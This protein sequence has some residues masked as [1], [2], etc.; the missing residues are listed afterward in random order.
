[1]YNDIL[2]KVR[3]NCNA[4]W[5]QNVEDKVMETLRKLYN[6]DG[7]RTTNVIRRRKKKVCEYDS[8]DGEEDR[9]NEVDADND[10]S[11]VFAYM[12]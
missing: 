2:E 9:G 7:R 11:T 4:S 8:S 1:M 3:A 12:V 10:L 6:C 5:A